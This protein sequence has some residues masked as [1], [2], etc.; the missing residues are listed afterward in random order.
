MSEK[1]PVSE[2][3]GLRRLLERAAG[4]TYR[5]RVRNLLLP[6]SIGNAEG[7][8]YGAHARD[9]AGDR[10]PW[11]GC[12]CRGGE[13]TAATSAILGSRGASHGTARHGAI[14]QRACGHLCADDSLCQRK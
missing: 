13:G 10:G 9:G 3:L 5:V 11:R 4:S 8:A 2:A 14:R 6:C 7:L 1:W 12:V